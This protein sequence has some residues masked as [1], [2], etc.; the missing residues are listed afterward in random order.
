MDEPPKKTPSAENKQEV[1]PP[2]RP[3]NVLDSIFHPDGPMPAASIGY[4]A[5]G[6]FLDFILVFIA[7]LALIWNL[8]LP[9]QHPGALH[10]YITLS[11]ATVHWIQ[12]YETVLIGYDQL[13]NNPDSPLLNLSNELK[14]AL[15]TALN[16]LFMTFWLYFAA[17]EAF[18]AGSSLG[19][20]L[21]CIR[22]VSTV[23]LGA[24]PFFT[25]V[26]R[27]GLKSMISVF[28]I[29]SPLTIVVPL[30]SLLFNKRK[31]LLHDILSRTAVIDEGKSST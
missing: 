3:S 4:R 23:T 22:V 27:G 6:F 10:E 21:C 16:V 5:L 8:V 20:R 15:A 11:E 1:P 25:A 7:S 12:S 29:L 19:K 28:F 17:S 2:L 18:F 31:Q 26:V 24:Q 30:I 9:T 14:D 13:L